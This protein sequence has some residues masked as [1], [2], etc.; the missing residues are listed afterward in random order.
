M[1][2]SCAKECKYLVFKTTSKNKLEYGYCKKLDLLMIA[3]QMD[4][5]YYKKCLPFTT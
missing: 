5:K 4:C 3:V 2:N 1:E